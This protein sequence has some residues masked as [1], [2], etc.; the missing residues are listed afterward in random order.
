M[1]DDVYIRERRKCSAF[2][3]ADVLAQLG[4]SAHMGFVDHR[5][6]PRHVGWAIIAPVKAVVGDNCLEHAR[7]AVATIEGEIGAR[8][9]HPVPEQC[10]RP[11]QRPGDLAG[12]G[13]E[14]QLVRV[15]TMTLLR[16]IRA[17]RAIAVNEPGVRIGKIAVPNLIGVFRQHELCDLAAAGRIEQAEIDALGAGGEHGKVHAQPVPGGAKRVRRAADELQ[18]LR[19]Q[20]PSLRRKIVASGG[21]RSSSDCP[22]PCEGTGSAC[23]RPSLPRFDP[24]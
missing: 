23:T 14:Q 16:R 13:V 4:Q 3:G 9:V 10:I 11:A 5:I 18:R 22:R 17:M 6:R 2:V 1:I 7:G 8:R 21:S 15:E 19:H 20:S 12:I 24:P